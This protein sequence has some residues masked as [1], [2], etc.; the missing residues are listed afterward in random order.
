MKDARIAWSEL[1]EDVVSARRDM[2]EANERRGKEPSL[3]SK[4]EIFKFQQSGSNSFEK[5]LT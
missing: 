1:F 5:R 3:F 4:E 2:P